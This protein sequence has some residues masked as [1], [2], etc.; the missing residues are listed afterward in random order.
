M[1]SSDE[2]RRKE[3]Y[4][5]ERHKELFTLGRGLLRILLG[6]YL[7][8]SPSSIKIEYSPYGKPYLQNIF[9]LGL[10][11]NLAHSSDLAVYAF[12]LDRQI[13]VDVECVRELP[14]AQSIARRFFTEEEYRDLQAL[15]EDTRLTGFYNCWTRKEAY[16]KAIGKGLSVPLQ[17]FRVSLIPGQ[18]AALLDLKGQRCPMPFCR[19][20]HLEPQLGYIG[21]LAV[22]SPSARVVSHAYLTLERC[23][24]SLG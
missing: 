11:F 4:H 3:A 22:A 8:R 24:A 15:P 12:G 18:A 5:L 7:D 16:L 21:A 10:S 23:L 2:R 14:D 20:V 9:R 19:L 17:A 13:G 1:L 6:R